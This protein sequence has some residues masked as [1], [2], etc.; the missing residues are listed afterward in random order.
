M[1]GRR[2]RCRPCGA[3]PHALSSSPRQSGGECRC[4]HGA[5]RFHPA[6]RINRRHLPARRGF[7]YRLR[8]PAGTPAEGLGPVLPGGRGALGRTGARG[9]RPGDRQEHRDTPRRIRGDYKS[10][11]PGYA[12]FAPFP[13]EQGGGRL[14]RT[15]SIA[16]PSRLAAT[17]AL[18]AFVASLRQT[19]VSFILQSV[20]RRVT[21]VYYVFV[22]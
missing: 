2:R 4:P 22:I 10:G 7:R 21:L 1:D 20:R 15:T 16:A 18:Q 5:R 12:R 17:P 14:T 13:P 3:R 8:H 9:N 19:P 6:S 11:R